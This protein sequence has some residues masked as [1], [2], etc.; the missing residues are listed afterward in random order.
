M[1]W[2]IHYKR[3]DNLLCELQ[4]KNYEQKFKFQEN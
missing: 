1:I 4:E 2:N 3:N